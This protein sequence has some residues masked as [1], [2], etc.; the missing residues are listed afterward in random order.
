MTSWYNTRAAFSVPVCT[1]SPGLWVNR[2]SRC[3]KVD[4]VRLYASYRLNLLLPKGAEVFIRYIKFYI[5]SIKKILQISYSGPVKT[6]SFV[7]TSRFLWCCNILCFQNICFSVFIFCLVFTTWCIN[8]FFGQ[9]YISSCI[10]T[11]Q[12]NMFILP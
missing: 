8:Q 3:N 10:Y 7:F 9:F 6:L 1:V 2:T 12:S 4:A 5:G 11:W